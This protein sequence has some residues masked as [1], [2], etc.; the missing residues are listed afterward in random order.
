MMFVVGSSLIGNRAILKGTNVADGK[1][2]LM[3]YYTEI[4]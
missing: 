4:E 3:I 2:K 1:V